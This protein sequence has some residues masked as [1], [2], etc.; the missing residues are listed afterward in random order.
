MVHTQNYSEYNPYW[1]RQTFFLLG[2]T[3][4]AYQESNNFQ[5]HTSVPTPPPFAVC[6]VD[7][8]FWKTDTDRYYVLGRVRCHFVKIPDRNIMYE[9]NKTSER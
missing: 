4:I 3:C 2:Y 9:L 5:Y 1:R 7:R 8:L 6:L